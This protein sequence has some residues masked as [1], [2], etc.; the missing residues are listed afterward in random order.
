MVFKDLERFSMIFRIR[1]LIQKLVK[2]VLGSVEKFS[3]P[4]PLSPL[5]LYLSATGVFRLTP[6]SL[7]EV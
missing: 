7:K 6:S 3:E 2:K 1:L 5:P 4:F